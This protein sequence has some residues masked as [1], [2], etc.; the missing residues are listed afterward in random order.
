MSMDEQTT[1]EQANGGPYVSEDGLTMGRDFVIPGVDPAEVDPYRFHTGRKRDHGGTTRS[2]S[3]T[4][5][6]SS[7]APASSTAS[8]SAC[9]RTRSRW[10]SAPRAPARAC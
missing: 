2:R 9:P 7:A 4:W 6:S 10:S 3:S 5:S 1:D 8:T